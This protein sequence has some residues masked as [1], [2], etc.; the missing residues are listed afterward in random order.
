MPTLTH[1]LP[2]RWRAYW[3][4]RRVR[5]LTRTVGW[6]VTIV[7][8]VVCAIIAATRWYI[9]PQVDHYRDD[10]AAVA[11]RVIGCQVQIGTIVPHWDSFWPQ[12]SLMDVRIQKPAAN[13][14]DAQVLE[15]PSV[16]ASLSWKTLLGQVEF[17]HLLVSG[18]Q[19]TVRRLTDTHFDIA[20]FDLDWSPDDKT[21]ESASAQTNPALAW[22]LKQG[23]IDIVNASV[24]YLDLSRSE[25]SQIAL[26]NIDLSVDNALGQ[27]RFGLQALVADGSNNAIDVRGQFTRSV[28]TPADWRKWSGRVYLAASHLDI[29]SLVQK[30]LPATSQFVKSGIGGTRTW[31]ELTDGKVTSLASDVQ[32]RDVALRLAEHVQPLQLQQVSARFEEE[33]NGKDFTVR[34]SHVQARDARGTDWQPFDASAHIVL[35]E[36]LRSAT[37][38]NISF[39]AIDLSRFSALLDTIPL[40]ASIDQALRR[41]HPQGQLQAVQA[42]WLGKLSS[43][44]HWRIQTQFDHVSAHWHESAGTEKADSLMAGFENLSGQLSVT[45]EQ[46]DVQI[47]SQQAALH[48]PRVFKVSPM[49]FDALSGGISWYAAEPQHPMRVIFANIVAQNA[50]IAAQARGSWRDTGG[51]GTLDLTGEFERGQARAVWK[52]MPR[53]VGSETQDWLEAGLV[54]GTAPKG[55]FEVIGA[56]DEFP[57][58]DSDPKREHFLVDMDVK[59]AAIDYVPNYQRDRSGAFVRASAWPLLTHINGRL[60]FEGLQMR[61]AAQSARTNGT[62]LG[63]V[64]A[65]IADLGAGESTTLSIRGQASA[66]LAKMLSYLDVSPVGQWTGNAFSNAKATGKA[67]L[68]LNLDIPLLHAQ[69]TRVAGTVK[70]QNNTLAMAYPVPP[71]THLTGAVHF[72]EKGATARRL[73]ARPFGQGDISANITT[74][75]NGTI[76][77]STSGKTDIEKLAYFA[78][79]TV[80]AD[81]LRNVSGQTPFVATVA[82]DPARGVTVSAQSSLEGVRSTLPA[83]LDKSA[84]ERWPMDVRITPVSIDQATGMLVHVGSARRFDVMLQVPD[85]GSKLPALGAVGIGRRVGLPA[86]GM[87]VQ[88]RAD[89]LV[90]NDWADTL[91]PLLE[92]MPTN[93]ESD[94]SSRTPALTSVRVRAK[95]IRAEHNALRDVD[96]TVE[97]PEPQH[98]RARLAS[99]RAT[100]TVSWQPGQDPDSHVLKLAFDRLHLTEDIVSGLRRFVQNESTQ[101]SQQLLSQL[102]V[103]QA[104]VGDLAFESMRFGQTHLQALALRNASTEQI[105]I[106]EL[107]S[108]TDA[109]TLTG[110]GFWTH[111]IGR[112][113]SHNAGQTTLQ[114]QLDLANAGRY[115]AQMGFA[116]VIRSAN[117]QAAAKLTYDGAPW[118]PI[119]DRLDGQVS[120]TLKNGSLM[121]VDTGPGGTL[122]DIFSFQ[123]LLKR[124]R[125]DF[126]DLADDGFT[127]DTIT[128]SARIENGVSHT[129]NT[130][131][132]G[133]HGSI[134]ISGGC[135]F[136]RRQFDAKAVV[137]P[138]VNAGN[139]SLALAFLNP[140]VGIGTFI[141]QLVLRDPLSRLFRIEY[142]VKGPFDAPKI[143]K[144]S[145]QRGSDDH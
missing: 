68:E 119:V 83:P 87:S 49:R 42:Q 103:V 38:G 1:F 140:A 57:W 28:F 131:I 73:Q 69:D 101:D 100:G 120:M 132:V 23:R 45:P 29:A 52:Y 102:P 135:D 92:A 50:D 32:L 25:P 145:S 90:L 97:R 48:L 64:T 15:L 127:F 3:R 130:K 138:D 26:T 58:T 60:T 129:D 34:M 111:A 114:L 108:K 20:G 84:S 46:A 82:I 80:L 143:E 8:F 63:P 10:I 47:D 98:Y 107:S 66:D 81:I 123:S 121:Q 118:D 116:G 106:T 126:R 136:A 85:A 122:L 40:P 31:L 12:L 109:G 37:S 74:A 6:T 22:L 27:T 105:H 30:A 88:V 62:T 41:L 91:R 128:G 44:T 76:S 65:L 144:V 13:G 113:A 125:L 112:N 54:A 137:L 14:R 86:S 134:L 18:A 104:D 51:A 75:K 99:D 133:T 67:Q 93:T 139:A 36:D 17:R 72:S 35:D 11:S 89:T 21:Q 61:V 43:P 7:Y 9:L 24:R 5:A 55:R 95:E 142:N 141:A 56:L 53:I 79:E 117:G 94:A 77:I 110:S 4:H 78:P 59:N 115:L 33:L 71:L 2:L 96:L 70:L 16:E 19:L 124:L 39:S